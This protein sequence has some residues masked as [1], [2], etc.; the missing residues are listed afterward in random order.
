VAAEIE[1]EV[2]YVDDIKKKLLVTCMSL[3]SSKHLHATHP[4]FVEVHAILDGWRVNKCVREC[5]KIVLPLCAIKGLKMAEKWE[6]S[7]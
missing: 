5:V 6:K 2:I 1:E 3:K 7:K 4:K